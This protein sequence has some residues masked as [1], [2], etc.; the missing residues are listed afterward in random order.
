MSDDPDSEQKRDRLMKEKE[1]LGFAQQHLQKVLA[2]D[3]EVL[4][5]D[6]HEIPDADDTEGLCSPRSDRDERRTQTTKKVKV[7]NDSAMTTPE[8]PRRPAPATPEHLR[9]PDQSSPL[10]RPFAS[11]VEDDADDI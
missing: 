1:R 2:S 9:R 7:E 10:K 4:V 6:D 5:V 8:T 11:T 3:A